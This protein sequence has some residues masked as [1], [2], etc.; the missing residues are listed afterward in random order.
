LSFNPIM[1]TSCSTR[2]ITAVNTSTAGATAASPGLETLR[3]IVT[4]SVG[5]DVRDTEKVALPPV[6]VVMVITFRPTNAR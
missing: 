4:V 1:V 3:A 6:A 2:L 5:T